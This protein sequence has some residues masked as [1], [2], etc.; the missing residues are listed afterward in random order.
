M[1]PIH[2]PCSIQHDFLQHQHV[3]LQHHV[4]VVPKYLTFEF[5]TS[6]FV[7]FFERFDAV[8]MYVLISYNVNPGLSVCLT[9]SGA[10]EGDRRP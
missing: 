1:P 5:L 9:R 8:S 7:W 2:I 3:F 4:V 10:S 6:H